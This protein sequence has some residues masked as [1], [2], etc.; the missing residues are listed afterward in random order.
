MYSVVTRFVL[1]WAPATELVN[2]Q[3]I[4]SSARLRGQRRH[5][6]RSHL[7]LRPIPEC[8][9]T[10]GGLIITRRCRDRV[11]VF[12]FELLSFPENRNSSFSL[13]IRNNPQI[14][15]R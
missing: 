10:S 14:P 15:V 7:R 3:L 5:R 1:I 9:F 6:P 13:S 4:R 8:M 11:S 12:A 2:S